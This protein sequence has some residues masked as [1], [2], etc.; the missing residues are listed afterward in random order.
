MLNYLSTLASELMPGAKKSQ[1]GDGMVEHRRSDDQFV[2]LTTTF[3]DLK[4]PVVFASVSEGTAARLDVTAG[5]S[6]L[7]VGD[8][9]VPVRVTSLKYTG[10]PAKLLITYFVPGGSHVPAGDVLRWVVRAMETP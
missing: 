6:R 10:R 1:V 3:D 8:G 4:T 5:T 9:E 7:R 2:L